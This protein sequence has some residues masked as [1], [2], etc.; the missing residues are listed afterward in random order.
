MYPFT[1]YDPLLNR[2]GWLAMHSLTLI[3]ILKLLL[4]FLDNGEKYVNGDIKVVSNTL[5]KL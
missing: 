5:Y 2:T 4:L 1:G 3:S